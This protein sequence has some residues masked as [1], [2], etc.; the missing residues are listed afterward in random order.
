[1]FMFMSGTARVPGGLLHCNMSYM[2][3]RTGAVKA[4]LLQRSKFF[5]TPPPFIICNLNI[6]KITLIRHSSLQGVTQF[7]L[8][9]P[10]AAQG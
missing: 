10:G 3:S 5:V 1:M 7:G 9:G 4:K 6:S 2:L 8:L